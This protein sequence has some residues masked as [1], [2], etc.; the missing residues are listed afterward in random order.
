MPKPKTVKAIASPDDQASTFG[1]LQIDKKAAQALRGLTLESPTA[2][3]VLFF[4]IERMSRTNSLMVGQ[5]TLAATIGVTSRSV[6]TALVLL[7]SRRFIER[8]FVGKSAVITVN[9]RVAWQGK[10]GERFAHFTAE[11]LA[12]EREQPQPLD[13]RPGLEPVPV[14]QD[15]ERLLVTNDPVDPPDQS[16]IELD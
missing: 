9:T 15:G 7:E 10:R 3:A 5:E 14:L 1:W 12:S 6:R 2:A 8:T 11:I 13:D 16:E 4:C